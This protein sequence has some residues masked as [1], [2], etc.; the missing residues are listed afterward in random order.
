MAPEL[1]RFDQQ[2]IARSFGFRSDK[3]SPHPTNRLKLDLDLYLQS[4]QADVAT[5][6]LTLG[7][8]G[9]KKQKY[10]YF[11]ADDRFFGDL[12]PEKHNGALIIVKKVKINFTLPLLLYFISFIMQ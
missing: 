5:N 12:V 8:K 4:L 6:R 10:F 2:I 1:T 9:Q 11:D 3:L 7:P